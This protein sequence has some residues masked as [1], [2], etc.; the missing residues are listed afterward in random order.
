MADKVT[1]ICMDIYRKLEKST[2]LN[3]IERLQVPYILEIC[4][5]HY[6]QWKYFKKYVS[7]QA[8][9][10]LFVSSVLKRRGNRLGTIG[11]IAQ[12]LPW[13]T[14]LINL[15]HEWERAS[16]KLRIK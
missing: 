11:Q 7:I 10:F 1:K 4:Y 2:V 6:L 16:K 3:I 13:A 15:P 12:G 9:I 8:S 5:L 14:V